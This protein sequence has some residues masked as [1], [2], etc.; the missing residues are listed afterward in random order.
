M[1]QRGVASVQRREYDELIRLLKEAR[2]KSGLTQGEVGR[3]TGLSQPVLSAI[4]ASSRRLDVVE[5]L[6]LADAIGFDPHEMIR[7]I[8]KAPD[9]T[10]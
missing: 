4:E 1:A 2:V 6:D 9:P 8:R 7:N 10:P 5:F 3:K